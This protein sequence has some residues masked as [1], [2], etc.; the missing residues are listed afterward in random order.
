MMLKKLGKSDYTNL[1]AYRPIALLNTLGKVLEAIILNRIK[2]ITKT[3]DL[4][5]DT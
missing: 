1:L 3:H 4:L 5:L 2:F